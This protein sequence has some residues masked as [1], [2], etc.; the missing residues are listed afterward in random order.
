MRYLVT[1]TPAIQAAHALDVGPR[2]PGP[3]FELIGDRSKPIVFCVAA[4]A[5]HR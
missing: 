2:G 1:I 5:A 4:G 3:L